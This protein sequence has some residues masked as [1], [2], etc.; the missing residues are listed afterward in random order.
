MLEDLEGMGFVRTQ[1]NSEVAQFSASAQKNMSDIKILWLN[2]L[3]K[4]A[5]VM[6]KIQSL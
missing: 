3:I 4:N 5:K 1:D 6:N 2:K